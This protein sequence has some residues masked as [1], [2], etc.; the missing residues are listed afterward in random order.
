MKTIGLLG[1]AIIGIAIVGCGPD[2]GG[3]VEIKGKVILK[4]TPLD[5]GL[6]DFMPLSG[7]QATKQGALIKNGEYT[8]PQAQGL[9]PGKYRVFITAGDGRTRANA[10]PDELPGPTGANIVSKDRIPKEYN[11]ES[12]QERE[13]TAKSPNVFDFDIK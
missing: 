2:Y 3:R 6:I 9:V 8:I 1:T 12:K 4:G 5:E 13:V 11:T 10:D 7:D